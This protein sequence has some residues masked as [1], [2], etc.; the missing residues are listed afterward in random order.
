MILIVVDLLQS[1]DE[2][3]ETSEVSDELEDP[4]HSHDPHQTNYFTSLANNLEILETLC[5][6]LFDYNIMLT[7]S[8]QEELRWRME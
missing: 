3:L 7:S 5:K 4:Q 2:W 8:N 1:D 6:V